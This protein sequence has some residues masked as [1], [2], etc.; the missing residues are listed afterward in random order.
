MLRRDFL[1]TVG[2][3]VAAGLLPAMSF[4]QSGGRKPNIIYIMA[5]DLGY[6][7]LGCYGQRHIKTPVLDAL[8]AGGVRFTDHYA[9]SPVCAPSRCCLMTGLHTGHAYVRGNF[10]I[11]PQGQLPLPEGTATVAR[12]LKEAGYATALIGKWGLGGPGSVGEPTK[13]GFDYFF[14][15][16][17]QRHAHNYYT[18]FVYRNG[19]RIAVEG[20]RMP[21]DS[22]P[23]GAGVAVEKGTWTPDLFLDEALR[24]IEQRKEGPF[25]LYYAMTIPHANNEG[26]PE[27][28]EVP[29]DE[30]YSREIWPRQQKN[31]AAMITRMDRDVG[32]LVEKI[33]ELGLEKDTLILFTS[34]NGPHRE[35]GNEPTFFQSSGPLRGTKRETYEGGVRVPMIAYWPGRIAPGRVSGH[36]SAFW[37]FLPTACDIAGVRA[38]TGIDGISFLPELLGQAQRKHDHLYWE[39]HE[40]GGKVGVRMGQ[41]K[42]V[43]VNTKKA[44]DGPIELYDLSI[45]IGET[46][47]IATEHPQIVER[48]ASI[49]KTARTPSSFPQWQ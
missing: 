25:F 6:G 31:C 7:D 15:Y 10:E 41:W 16:M 3:G 9:G 49:M 42:G 17:C 14:G 32:R 48:L 36:V 12:L 18:D 43:R 26:G 47:N 44:P 45:D 37:D 13:Q 28:M 11:Q 21:P 30:P 33:K 8:A 20:N 34:D 23:D 5:D 19:E 2:A 35:G 27:G 39:F 46:R 22:R 40:Q 24:F 4:A 1:K 38:P 29:S